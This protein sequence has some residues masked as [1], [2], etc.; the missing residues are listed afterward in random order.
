MRFERL[1][2]GVQAYEKVKILREEYKD[3]PKMTAKL[4]AILSAFKPGTLT[5]KPAAGVVAKAKQELNK[6]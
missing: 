3:N 4:N 1:I 2:Q 6:L 5:E